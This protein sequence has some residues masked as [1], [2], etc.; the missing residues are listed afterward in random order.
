M[1]AI[2][3]VGWAAVQISHMAIV[4][5]LSYGQRRRDTMV[6]GRNIFTYVANIFML[7]LSLILFLS[8]PSA[9]ACFRILTVVCLSLGGVTTLFY[10]FSIKEVPLSKEAK[11]FDT[12]YKLVT[13]GD[14]HL[15]IP[16][17]ATVIEPE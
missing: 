16:N 10:V 14:N 17:N 7:S 1:P 3:N 5:Q 15:K 13:G 4:N 2:F 11:E 6:N 9:T 12:Q 8:I